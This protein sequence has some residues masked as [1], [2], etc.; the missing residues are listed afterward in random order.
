MRLKSY[1]SGTVEEAMI[2]AGQELGPEAMLVY[3]REASPEARYLGRYEVVF[4]LPSATESAPIPA[5]EPAQAESSAPSSGAPAPGRQDPA[6]DHLADQVAGLRRQLDRMSHTLLRL[7]PF[8]APNMTLAS[9]AAETYTA[10]VS[11]EVSA[12][13]AAEIAGRIGQEMA[14]HP[15]QESSF[16]LRR[17]L[18]SRIR[19]DARLGESGGGARAVALIGPPG[20]GKTTTLVKLAVAYGLK[21]RR[22][23]QLLCMDMCRIG[24]SD[25][26]RTYA[27]IL[28]VGFQA[29]DTVGGL[30]QAIDDH[31]ARQLILIDTPGH[32]QTDMDVA[33]E[34]ARF[35]AANP[36]VDTHLVLPA[37]MKP[38]D[39]TR[40]VERFSA[41][42]PRK[43]L[44]TRLDETTAFGALWSEAARTGLP[45][46]FL[47]NGPQIPEDIEEA[48]PERV[49][50]L[51]LGGEIPVDSVAAAA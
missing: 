46:S 11:A 32:T 51:V 13:L 25:Q 34:L 39:L 48:N 16:A 43:L 24:G 5:A 6:L 36:E 33:D 41:F 4:A 20:S 22:S 2:S 45:V 21:S 18:A 37:S 15:E 31:R 8:V 29:L 49:V 1:F 42:A 23:T 27:A 12:E 9:P 30:A 38:Q 26:L 14:A 19:A 3:S 35:L 47:T 44:F 7:G 28:G 50:D 17:L 10:L 40:T